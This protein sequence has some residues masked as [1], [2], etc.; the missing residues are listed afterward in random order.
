MEQPVTEVIF[1]A[2]RSSAHV[3]KN[4]HLIIGAKIVRTVFGAFGPI[5][6]DFRLQAG[7]HLACQ[8]RIPSA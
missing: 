3:K 6:H 8:R 7:N 5:V 2:M 4:L 1:Q